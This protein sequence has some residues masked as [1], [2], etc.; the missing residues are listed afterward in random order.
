M[1]VYDRLPE[2]PS[3]TDE[4]VWNDFAKFYLIGLGGRGQTALDKFG[5]WKDIEQV[6]TA[7]VGRRDWAPGST[8]GVERIFEGRKFQTQVLPRDKL[9]SALYKHIQDNYVDQIELNYGYEIRPLDFANNGGQSVLVEVSKCSGETEADLTCETDSVVRIATELLIAA[10][11]TARTIAN[12]ME[13]EDK[14]RRKTMN[15]IHRLFAGK[16]FTVRRYSDDSP[17]V[18]KTI[19]M[20]L[21]PGW[22]PDLNYSARSRGG[23]M[24]LD[25]LP[26]NRNGDYCAVLLLRKGD[27]MAEPDVDPIIFRKFLDDLLPQFSAILSEELVEQVAKKPPSFLPSFR[28]VGPRLN[29]GD[30]TIVLG[31]CAHTVKPYFGL[32]A[33]SALE[34]VKVLSDAIDS[35]NSLTEAVH[36]FS[37]QR[38]K[39]SELLVK[40][41]RS[42]DRPGNM[43]KITFVVPIILDSIFNKIAPKVFAPN[44]ITM[45]QREDLTFKQVAF[46]K[47]WDR[48]FQLTIIG[49][50]LTALT[51]GTSFVISSIARALGMR[52]STLTLMFA[53]GATSALILRKAMRFM[54]PGMA[55]ADVLAKANSKITA[56]E[57]ITRIEEST[58]SNR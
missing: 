37:R 29:Q 31:D 55:P 11:G 41:S 48:F 34:D 5:V 32:G 17:R 33:N 6:C 14:D 12:A 56:K 38:A 49:G 39:E 50:I 44:I 36:K 15:P 52:N 4:T 10:D 27:E 35:T 30:R 1:C 18:Y 28:Y 19:P 57:S 13:K 42:L 47:R 26:A 16:P 45:L 58:S 53:L 46:R 40:I 25:A 3:P 8:E 9:V 54:V 43:G 23:R 22:R 7:V 2:P 21:P 20:K 51:T 24:N